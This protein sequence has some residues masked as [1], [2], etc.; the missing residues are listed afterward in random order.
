[1]YKTWKNS[2]AEEKLVS[3]QEVFHELKSM[4]F[5][6]VPLVFFF[7]IAPNFWL[8]IW[9]S[10]CALSAFILS[11]GSKEKAGELHE[12]ILTAKK[13]ENDLL[14]C[15]NELKNSLRHIIKSRYCL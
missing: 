6:M 14:R 5:A 3:L 13:D 8:I 4:I 1:M 15:S 11:I 10:L 12:K 9:V 7:F 2:I